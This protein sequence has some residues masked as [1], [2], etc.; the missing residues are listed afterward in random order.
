MDE[1][2]KLK[3]PPTIPIFLVAAVVSYFIFA[4][5]SVDRVVFRN[6][7][8]KLAE[9]ERSISPNKDCIDKVLTK[10]SDNELR[11]FEKEAKTLSVTN[12]ITG[13]SSSLGD[14]YGDLNDCISAR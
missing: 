8:V 1:K 11:A 9:K 10:Y 14:F 12:H 13:P 6:N 4:H 3:S 5:G 7:F 2:K